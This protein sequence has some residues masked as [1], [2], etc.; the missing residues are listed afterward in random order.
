CGYLAASSAEVPRCATLAEWKTRF[1]GWVRDPI[2]TQVYHARPL[3][4]LRPALGPSQP[5]TDLET[6]VR[7]ELHAEPGFLQLLAHDCLANLPP[8]TFFRDLVVEE[9]GEQSDVFRLE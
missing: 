7:A 3:F 9:S 2:R 6:H 5:W 4:D 8:L 1:S